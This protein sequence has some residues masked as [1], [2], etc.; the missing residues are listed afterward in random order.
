[1][2]S[3]SGRALTQSADFDSDAVMELR[4]DDEFLLTPLEEVSD[5]ESQD[6]GSQVIALESDSDIDASSPTVLGSDSGGMGGFL[7]DTSGMLEPLSPMGFGE[8][9]GLTS[10]T[11]M[12]GATQTPQGQFSGLSVSMLSFCTL[13]IGLAGLMMFDVVRNIWSWDTP[14]Q[15]S[16]IVMDAI[17]GL[18]G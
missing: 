8:S 7:D 1:M 18:V 9:G 11:P 15:I 6:S 5:E 10:M 13:L 2:G 4:T 16:S 3:D 17:L 14:Y 12:Y